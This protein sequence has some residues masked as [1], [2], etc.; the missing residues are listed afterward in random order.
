MPIAFSYG[1]PPRWRHFVPEGHNQE[2]NRCVVDI[3]S[4]QS[5][6]VV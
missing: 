2:Q 3:L 1:K 6:K 4:S 5:V